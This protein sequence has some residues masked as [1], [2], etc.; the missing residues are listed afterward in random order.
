MNQSFNIRPETRATTLHF[1]YRQLFVTPPPVSRCDA[2]LD[3]K[4]AIVIG[5]NV[6]LGLET[7]RQLLDLGAKVILA[8]RDK[9]KGLDACKQLSGSQHLSD[10]SIEFVNRAR[11]LPFLD[12]AIL[13]AGLYNVHES[14]SSTG[15]EEDIHI[16]YL[17]NLL[18]TLLLLPVMKK[19]GSD[20]GRIVLVSS[21]QA[22][23]AKFEERRSKPLLP[24]FKR[25]MKDWDMAERY[26]TSKF[27]GLLFV[28]E[29]ARLSRLFGRRCSIGTRTIVHA[30]TVLGEEAHGQ[31]VED[32]KVQPMP[33]IV[34]AP[35][36]LQLAKLLYE[37]T[38]SDMAFVGVR[39]SI[40]RLQSR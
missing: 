2:D 39:D 16:N 23:W 20:S 14:F 10:D 5:S 3:G 31:Y 8:V 4:R 7:A 11:E 12:I 15:Y 13:N 37:E 29:L 18:L 27:L 6:G 28:T 30:A 32:A 38:L 22:A 34:Y 33:P 9:S 26:G 19:S 25:K 35:E 21:D 36:D 24:T 17:S 1:L 40:E